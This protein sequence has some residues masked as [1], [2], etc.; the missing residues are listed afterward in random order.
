MDHFL[1]EILDVASLVDHPLLEKAITPEGSLQYDV[2]FENELVINSLSF[3]WLHRELFGGIYPSKLIK[4]THDFATFETCCIFFETRTFYRFVPPAEIKKLLQEKQAGYIAFREALVGSK[5][6]VKKELF[7]KLRER[8]CPFPPSQSQY[9]EWITLYQNYQKLFNAGQN[10]A[11]FYDTAKTAYVL[12]QNPITK[13]SLSVK[14]S[15]P[16]DCRTLSQW[17]HA[18]YVFTNDNYFMRILFNAKLVMVI[19]D[20]QIPSF[21]GLDTFAP[22]MIIS[23][24]VQEL[25]T[26]QCANCFNNKDLNILA[27]CLPKVAGAAI[28][29]QPTLTQQPSNPPTISLTRTPNT[30]VKIQPRADLLFDSLTQAY[31]LNVL[32]QVQ[33]S[34]G[35]PPPT[36][37][38]IQDF[39]FRQYSQKHESVKK[40]WM[41]S[42]SADLTSRNCVLIIDNREN[43]ST[44]MSAYITLSNLRPDYWDVVILTSESA[45]PFYREHLPFVKTFIQHPLMTDASKFNIETYNFIMKDE[46]T[47]LQLLGGTYQYCLTIQD[48]GMLIR[49][50]ME[51]QFMEQGYDYVGA[52]WSKNQLLIDAGVDDNMVG[53]G[54]LSLRNIDV[55]LDICKCERARGNTL[56]NNDM[57]P[58]PE[59]V[60]FVSAIKKRG[61]K[62]PTFVQAT[63]FAI[64]QTYC[65]EALGFH[66]PWPYIDM[67]VLQNFFR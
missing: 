44:I 55:M 16:A 38:L 6:R 22:T 45:K 32:S 54:G 36:P 14:E 20:E 11:Q 66:K 57:Q 8:V 39:M 58:I 21:K 62:M 5:Q 52:P 3:A 4:Q 51:A 2:I 34:F 18:T 12:G 63:R 40:A 25:A 29:L 43:I 56:F 7:L 15:F 35:A 42:S 33:M 47:W 64:E 67:K 49:P 37:P 19:T 50:G 9:D 53:N 26:N 60:F 41:A 10:I 59:D 28:Y 13:F 48:D 24:V 17:E 27:A 65:E 30:T 61:G 23:S 46:L 1:S 31:D